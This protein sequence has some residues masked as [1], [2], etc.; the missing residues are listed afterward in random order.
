M[1]TLFRVTKSLLFY[2]SGTHNAE[3]RRARPRQS[4]TATDWTGWKILRNTA[5]DR[6]EV[7]REK[8]T[9]SSIN[10]VKRVCS[11]KMRVG[12]CL[13]D[14]STTGLDAVV[15]RRDRS[16]VDWICFDFFWGRREGED[17][18]SSLKS[19]TETRTRSPVSNPPTH[20]R[21][22]AVGPWDYRYLPY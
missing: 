16:P 1:H 6:R 11:L 19:E 22:S 10:T 15:V 2:Q 4:A 21:R 7:G 5:S 13:P 3:R 20:K 18:S 8:R 14:S 17:P 9:N 12:T